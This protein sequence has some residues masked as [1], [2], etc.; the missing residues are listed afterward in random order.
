MT[1]QDF[2]INGVIVYGYNAP[3][4]VIVELTGYY[5]SSET[6]RYQFYAG[7]V[8]D[9]LLVQIGAGE[10]FPKNVNLALPVL[11]MISIGEFLSSDREYF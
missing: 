8:D 1:I 6:G 7:F 11:L 3:N 2:G 4:Q 9:L 5:V 10:A